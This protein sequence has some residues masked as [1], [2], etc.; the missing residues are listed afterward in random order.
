[1]QPASPEPRDT[2]QTRDRADL[3]L[4]VTGAAILLAATLLSCRYALQLYHSTAV[5]ALFIGLFVLV[6]LIVA[7]RSRRGGLPKALLYIALTFALP[8]IAKELG[9]YGISGCWLRDGHGLGLFAFLGLALGR[10]SIVPPI[11]IGAIAGWALRR[12]RGSP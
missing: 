3:L 11:A 9:I 5:R 10:Y 8:F 4:W 12:W 2:P 6:P 7:Y 1:M